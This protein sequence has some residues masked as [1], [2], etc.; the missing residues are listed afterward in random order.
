MSSSYH[1]EWKTSSK[2]VVSMIYILE[3]DFFAAAT[4]KGLWDASF[5]TE[6]ISL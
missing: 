1:N 3:K 6:Y 4:F 2:Q 5:H